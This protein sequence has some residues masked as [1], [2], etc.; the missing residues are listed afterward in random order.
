MQGSGF[1]ERGVDDLPGDL[2]VSGD[3]EG[4]AGVVVQPGDDLGVRSGVQPGPGQLLAQV[5]D[6]LDSLR[7]GGGRAGVRGPGTGL[8]RG[9]AFGPVAGQ[10]LIDPGTGHPVL[11]HDLADRALLD[12]DSGDDQA[13]LRHTPEGSRGRPGCPGTSVRHVVRHPSGMS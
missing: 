3:L 9:L 12:G 7:R 6:Q 4:V 13:R 5:Q 8:E 11:G 2:R 10:E 1:G